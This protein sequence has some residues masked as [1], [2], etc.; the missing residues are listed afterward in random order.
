MKRGRE[1]QP[2]G[3]DNKILFVPRDERYNPGDTA[4]RAIHCRIEAGLARVRVRG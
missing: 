3:D 4:M 2:K 1:D